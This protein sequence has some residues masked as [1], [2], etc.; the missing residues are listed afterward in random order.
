MNATISTETIAAFEAMLD[1]C[2]P[3]FSLHRD[4]FTASKT[5]RELNNAMYVELLNEYVNFINE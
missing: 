3:S 1:E 2:Y 5:I 4:T